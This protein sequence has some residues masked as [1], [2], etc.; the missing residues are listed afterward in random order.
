MIRLVFSSTDRPDSFD[1]IPFVFI[2]KPPPGDWDIAMTC[3][4]DD[5]KKSGELARSRGRIMHI[6]DDLVASWGNS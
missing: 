1:G 3:M 4:Y 6:P 2:E 5:P